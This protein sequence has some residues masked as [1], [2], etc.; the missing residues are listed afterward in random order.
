MN[1]QD[2]LDKILD[3]EPCRT[4]ASFREV[5]IPCANFFRDRA[6]LGRLRSR[7]ESYPR[8]VYHELVILF[9]VIM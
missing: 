3:D 1:C 6:F 5:A 9:V 7:G 2:N 4:G 8:E